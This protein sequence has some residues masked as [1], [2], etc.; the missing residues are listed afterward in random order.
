[1]RMKSYFAPT[2]E[3]AMEQARREM[4]PEALLVNSRKAPPEAREL[5]E[6]E[7]VFAVMPDG[8]EAQDAPK[9]QNANAAGTPADDP[10]MRELARLRNQLDEMGSALNAQVSSWA[11][12]APECAAVF[13]RLV[14]NDFSV[15]VAKKVV[16]QAYERLG[17]D[18]ASWLRRRQPYDGASIERAVRVELERLLSVDAGLGTP[19]ERGRVVALVGPPGSGKTSTLVKLAVRQGMASSRPVQLITTDTYRV[20]AAEQLRAYAAI[21][22]AGL[23]TVDTVRALQQAVGAHREKRLILIDTQGY[24]ASDMDEA[25]ELARFLSRDA[26]AEVHVV[27]PASMRNADLSR[28]I[29]RFEVFSPSKIIF[30]RLDETASCGAM[31]SESVRTGKAISFLGTGQRIPE[32]L[33]PATVPYLLDAV[34]ER[35]AE[36]ALSAA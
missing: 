28:T 27:V 26:F 17:S 31:I 29:D 12:P 19:E 9:A 36:R 6:Y 7:V 21:L 25:S 34:S 8:A 33:E 16:K 10:V 35:R 14:Q 1:M 24:A 23:E 4:G 18:P 13:S 22:G 2:V 3:D 30:T 20:G 15:E 32:D 11:V 5:G